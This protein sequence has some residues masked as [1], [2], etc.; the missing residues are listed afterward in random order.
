[1]TESKSMLQSEREFGCVRGHTVNVMNEHF[2]ENLI[3]HPNLYA[4]SRVASMTY[5]RLERS[6]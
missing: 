5:G 4:V 1:M 3:H 6:M 2:G